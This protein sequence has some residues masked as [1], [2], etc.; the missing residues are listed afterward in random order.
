M[1]RDFPAILALGGSEGGIPFDKFLMD[2]LASQGYV[3]LR[4]AYFKAESLPNELSE[5]PL[6]YFENSLDFLLQ[7][8]SVNK[9]NIGV[10]GVSKGAE[11]ALLLASMN[12]TV[13]AVV[14]HVPSNVVWYGLSQNVMEPK[15]S[16]T[17][18]GEG[19]SFMPYGKPDVGWQTSRIAD[20]YEA[21]FAQYPEKEAA[22]IIASR[23]N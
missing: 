6:E 16:W 4:L 2:S 9:D 17:S 12:S 22:A 8:K 5:I 20:Y 3:V 21:G 14:A 18:N 7:H 1:R 11:A 15:S 23:K 13:K 19:L 10:L